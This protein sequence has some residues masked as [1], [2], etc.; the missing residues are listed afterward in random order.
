MF[1][2]GKNN[3]YIRFQPNPGFRLKVWPGRWL[4]WCHGFGWG[5]LHPEEFCSRYRKGNW[6]KFKIKQR[7]E[8]GA[9]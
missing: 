8:K 5:L 6:E 7:E 1:S 2:I 4:H 9:Q 3:N